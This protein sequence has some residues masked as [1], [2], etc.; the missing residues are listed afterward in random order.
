[1]QTTTEKREIV[2]R[3]QAKVDALQGLGR[4]A[5][6]IS[7]TGFAPFESAFPDRIFPVGTVHEFL[8]D[9]SSHAA[10]TNGFIA[11]LASTFLNKDGICLW[12][13]RNRKV[14]PPG[15]KHFGITPSNVI[16]VDLH[17][18]NDLLWA[19]EEALK[20]DALTSVVGEI[21][22]LGFTESRRLQLA[23]EKSGVTGFIHC[24]KP[25][26]KGSSAC[27]TRWRVTPGMSFTPGGLPGIG[28]AVWDVELL[29]VRNGKPGSWR[30]GWIGNRF[31]TVDDRRLPDT[32]EELQVG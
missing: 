8:S 22:D 20:C 23:V 7:R 32:L 1:M 26:A 12:I 9:E 24:H 14:F 30:I 29:K 21:R 18:Q 31:M 3:L 27:T 16:F 28:H 15:L 5:D 25:K 17:K 11:G 2:K 13:G 6:V 19:I 4:P 10:C